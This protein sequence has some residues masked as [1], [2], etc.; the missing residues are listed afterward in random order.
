MVSTLWRLSSSRRPWIMCL[1]VVSTS[2][3]IGQQSTKL[4]PKYSRSIVHMHKYEITPPEDIYIDIECQGTAGSPAQGVG[5]LIVYG[6][7]GKQNDVDSDVFDALYV[8]EKGEMVMQTDFDMNGYRVLNSNNYIH[9]YLDTRNG[10]KFK[11]NGLDKILIPQKSI[12]K[13]IDFYYPKSQSVYPQLRFGVD[14]NTGVVHA[15]DISRPEQYNKFAFD[16]PVED[17][18]PFVSVVL[19]PLVPKNVEIMMLLTYIFP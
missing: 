4:F 13:A 3:N 8:L 19:L 9:G 1:N 14:L 15:Y 10:N 5:H 11:L 2:L 6:I 12:I 7:E 16:L 18:A 17:L